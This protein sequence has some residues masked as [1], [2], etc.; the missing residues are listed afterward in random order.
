MKKFL[1]CITLLVIITSIPIAAAA[2]NGG[3]NGIN[4][5]NASQPYYI[6][7][8]P[9][10]D[11]TV[12]EIF[13]M[14]GTTNLPVSE[15]V[16]I[17]IG[18]NWANPSGEGSSFTANVAVLQGENGANFWS[19]NITPTLWVT[20][21]VGA[22]QST[23]DIEYFNFGNFIGSVSSPKFNITAHSELFAISSVEP[24][25]PS[26][27]TGTHTPSQTPTT[28]LS[29]N[30]TGAIPPPPSPTSASPLSLIVPLVAIV[31]IVV[32]YSTGRNR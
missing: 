13:F 9:I 22:H 25:T 4:Q 11:H 18:P 32:L 16:S 14:N 29:L 10:G 28:T 17:F 8:D 5:T 12:N 31:G 19:C 3:D 1:M 6:T 26:I 24:N 20:R 23:N 30:Q 27:P 2:D 7:I 15:N 21:L